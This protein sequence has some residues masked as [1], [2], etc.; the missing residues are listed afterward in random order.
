MKYLNLFLSKFEFFVL[1]SSQFYEVS[2]TA[3]DFQVDIFQIAQASL[4]CKK[5]LEMNL[6]R[7]SLKFVMYLM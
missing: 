2:S 6:I 3:S 5:K 7:Y 4:H 1:I